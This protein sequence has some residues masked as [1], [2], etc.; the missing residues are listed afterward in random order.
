MDGTLTL[1][2]L[3][4]SPVGHLNRSGTNGGVKHFHQ[5]LL[6]GDIKRREVIQ[7]TLLFTAA[8]GS[9]LKGIN[10]C[11]VHDHLHRG[12]RTDTVGIQEG[13]VNINNFLI[14]PYHFKAMISGDLCH[15]YGFKVFP[16][17]HFQKSIK[18]FFYQQPQ[19]FFP[20]IR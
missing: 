8:M 7:K 15:R 20:E 16:V 18:V 9:T 3:P 12:L 2:E 19:P 6:G 17:S 10:I 5:S 1:R 11:S 4:F 13:S 14:S